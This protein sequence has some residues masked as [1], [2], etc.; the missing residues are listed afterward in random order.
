MKKVLT[1]AVLTTL[2]GCGGGNSL[3]GSSSSKLPN[4]GGVYSG[5]LHLD[6]N[7][8]RVLEGSAVITV[9]QSG[10]S[11]TL[12]GTISF[13]GSSTQLAPFQCQVD[14]TGFV[15]ACQGGSGNS[16]LNDPD[17]GTV[18]G[19]ATSAAFHGSS[20]DYSESATTTRCGDWHVFG[21]LTR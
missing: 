21:T 7:N 18:R 15:S 17:C 19:T 13:D 14:A 9:N 5:A 12:T 16:V 20:L 8:S 10:S 4:V 3:T 2:A 11:V 1:L 6:V